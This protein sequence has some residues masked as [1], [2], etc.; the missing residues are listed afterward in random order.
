MGKGQATILLARRAPTIKRW[1]LDA[2]SERQV[3]CPYGEVEESEG[4]RST[5]AV[6]SSSRPCLVGIDMTRRI[7]MDA[8][9]MNEPGFTF[10]R[11]G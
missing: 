2:R 4:S 6:K 9:D 7:E 3:A 10:R 8:R 5:A 1:S 11:G